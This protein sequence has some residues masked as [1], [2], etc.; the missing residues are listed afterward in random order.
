MNYVIRF[1]ENY[2]KGPHWRY[3]SKFEND[4]AFYTYSILDAYFFEDK[5]TA[6]SGRRVLNNKYKDTKHKVLSI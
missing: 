6:N 5:K 1:L 3:L 4:T 2:G